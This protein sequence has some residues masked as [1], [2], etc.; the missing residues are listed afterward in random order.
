MN[1]ILVSACL[2]GEKVRYDGKIQPIDPNLLSLFEQNLPIPVCPECDGGLPV[3]RLPAEIQGGDGRCVI[4]G[5]CDILRKDGVSVRE[6]FIRGA[7]IA[8]DLV[9]KYSIGVAIL[10]S[11]SPSC[12]N[13]EIYDGT[14]SKKLIEG[15]GV[16]VALLERYGVKVYN[17]HEI[18]EA[19]AHFE[20]L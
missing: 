14:F 17:E 4:D 5:S 3:P 1:K 9:N 13:G 16:T 10:K 11:K 12:S 7:N 6:E 15:V 20:T 18:V 8:L 19:I 2:L